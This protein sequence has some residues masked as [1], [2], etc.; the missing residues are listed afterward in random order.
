M[1]VMHVMLT[2]YADYAGD[3]VCMLCRKASGDEMSVL[4]V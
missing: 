1:H 2:C 3:A 4:M